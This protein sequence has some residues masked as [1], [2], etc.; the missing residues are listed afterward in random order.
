M[1]RNHNAGPSTLRNRNRVTNKT[2]LK[3]ITESIDADPIVLDE[4]EEKAR[5]VS[6]AGVDAE[7]ANEHHLQAVLSAAATRH[8]SSA[9]S[10]RG[11]L[12]KEKPAPVAY[13]PTPDSTGLVDNYEEL[14]PPER[15]KDPATYVKF[16]DTVEESTL[17]ALA[18]GFIYYMDE[19]DKEWLDRNNAEAGGEG[20]SAQGALSGTSTRSG[21]ASKAKGKDP[22]VAQAVAMSEDEFELVMAIFEKVTHEKTEFLH[23]GLEQGTPFPPFTDY[24]DTFAEELKPSMFALYTVPDWVPTPAHL[25]R[26]ARAIY[27]HWQER[28][29]ERG[30]HPIIPVVNLDE[31]DT[32]NESYICFRRREIK[33]VRKT[34]AQQATYSDKMMRLQTELTQAFD[35]ASAVLRREQLRREACI[36]S[37]AVWNRRC[38]LVDL[39]RK[40]PSLG[41]KE[42]EELFHDKERVAKKPK[43]E[44]ARI[45]LRLRTRDNGD[46]L[47]PVAHEAAIKPKERQAH[48]Q[49][50]VDQD[51]ARRKEKD[52][53][54]EDHTDN[55]YQPPPQPYP[56][57]LFKY[58]T[59]SR[60]ASQSSA[61]SD[62]TIKPLARPPRAGR[63]RFGRG[64]RIHLDR[65]SYSKE[66]SDSSGSSSSS[67]DSDDAEEQ[68]HKRR[69]AERWRYDA[70]DVPM[71]GPDGPEEK[72]RVL[73][74]DYDSKYL[75]HHMTLLTEQDLGSL[76]TDPTLVVT[77]S[78]GRQQ[79]I[80]PFRPGS[81]GLYGRSMPPAPRQLTAPM[82]PARPIQSLQSSSSGISI[83]QAGTPVSVATQ[84]KPM[85]PPTIPHMRISSNGGIRVPG[86]PAINMQAPLA[87]PP[88]ASAMAQTNGNHDVSGHADV[89]EQPAKS[90]ALQS[91]RGQQQGSPERQATDASTAATTSPMR[92]KAQPPQAI[93]MPTVPNGYHIPNV[94]AYSATMPNATYMHA[95]NRSN[96]LTLQQMQTMKSAYASMSPPPDNSMQANT[97]NVQLRTPGSYLGHVHQNGHPNY[98][99]LANARHM[100]QWAAAAVAQQQRPPSAN[101]A[102][103]NGAD[104]MPPPAMSP[105][106]PA[107]PVRTPSANGMRTPMSRGMAVPG[108]AHAMGQP[109]GRASPANPHMARIATPLTPSPHLLNTSLAATQPQGSPTRSPQPPMASPSMQARQ[110][111]GSSGAGY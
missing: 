11:T 95:N 105:P 34:R 39:K 61:S 48:I 106:L 42:D 20:T 56:C 66:S 108:V 52:Q 46:M 97:A 60:S 1:P 88:A 24:Q 83:S 85:A 77:L 7:D 91:P 45:P 68:D 43:P 8:Q 41:T 38:D 49:Q 62:A 14:Y 27:P 81:Q 78:D 54:W 22:D 104:G 101:M 57:K 23:H 98:A 15:W 12:E 110:A 90:P 28:R 84:L 32:M 13:I 47:S 63:L 17:F 19:R 40:F 74:D 71:V 59:S 31:M 111:V 80:T 36:H 65:R 79:T 75:V 87:S 18:D 99:Q 92:A 58:I 93:T 102:E 89:T 109:Q 82:T 70:D 33:A 5:V 29:M 3:V 21:R 50:L 55:P 72:D 76:M 2:R 10:T 6:T 67:S 4:D 107:M 51:L 53:K 96:G 16:S 86:L 35:I 64:G 37:N 44:N 100:Q 103:N 25:S 9:R 73:V 69:L 30:G 94:N 26:L